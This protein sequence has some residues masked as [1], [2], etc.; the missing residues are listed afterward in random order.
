MWI[1]ATPARSISR[2]VRAMLNALP[3][4]VSD[5]D[6]QRQIGRRRYAPRVLEHVAERR[7]A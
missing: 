2:T 3:K 4:P 5:V 1:A 7:D 6:E